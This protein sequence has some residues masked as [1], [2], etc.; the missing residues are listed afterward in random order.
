MSFNC[1]IS[2]WQVRNFHCLSTKINSIQFST[3]G[4]GQA[5][6]QRYLYPEWMK[7]ASSLRL[8]LLSID[9]WMKTALQSDVP[10]SDWDIEM[11]LK[12]RHKNM[13]FNKYNLYVAGEIENGG[14]FLCLFSLQDKRLKGILWLSSHSKKVRVRISVCSPHTQPIPKQTAK[15]A[16]FN[17]VIA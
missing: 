2:G 12:K 4:S 7:A 9:L 8:V 13:P 15:I 5:M 14:N 3:V 16:Y 1:P 6:L 10:T 11:I 17:L